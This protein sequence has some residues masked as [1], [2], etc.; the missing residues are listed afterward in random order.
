[1]VGPACTCT[2]NL[3]VLS[4][5]LPNENLQ[6]QATSNQGKCHV[7]S[8]CTLFKTPRWYKGRVWHLALL[9]FTS[10]DVQSVHR[11]WRA[12]DSGEMWWRCGASGSSVVYLRRLHCTHPSNSEFKRLIC[13]VSGKCSALVWNKHENIPSPVP[14]VKV[15]IGPRS[16][17]NYL[18][19]VHARLH[20]T[21]QKLFTKF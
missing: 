6:A 13:L 21:A 12:H 17:C 14:K 1:M 7:C 8:G 15:C 11:E 10:P 5:N 16:Q 9:R 4:S 2:F 18:L 3:C 19:C 20:K